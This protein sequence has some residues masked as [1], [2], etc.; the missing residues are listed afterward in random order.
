MISLSIGSEVRDQ[1]AEF[2]A[3][4]TPKILEQW[5]RMNAEQR[6]C[7]GAP[8]SHAVPMDSAAMSAILLLLA[9]PSFREDVTADA[10]LEPVLS[11][12]RAPG[13]QAC[14]FFRDTS[15]L[16]DAI[17]HVLDEYQGIESAERHHTRRTCLS[18]LRS[19]TKQV[20]CCTT[21]IYEHILKSG[22]RAF[23][24]LDEEGR[25]L[26][27]NERMRRLCGPLDSVGRLF[28]DLFEGDERRFVIDALN[29]TQCEQPA[30]RVLNISLGNR[31][32]IPVGVELGPIVIRGG[33]VGGFAC[34]VD[35]SI[36]KRAEKE[37]LRKS[38]IGIVKVTL[39]GVFTFCNTE[40]CRAFGVETLE[41]ASVVDFLDE[42]NLRIVMDQLEKRKEGMGDEYEI[43]LTRQTD[44]SRIP[45]RISSMPET[46]LKGNVVG[47]VA[48]VKDLTAEK[49]RKAIHEHMEGDME[50]LMILEAAID[51]IQRVMPF[52]R[53]YVA[54]YSSTMHH[55]RLLFARS[56]DQTP[57]R[58]FR[59][60]EMSEELI[61]WA[62]D[63]N[64][65]AIG[66]LRT[67]DNDPRWSL[68]KE[69]PEFRGLVDHGFTS[70]VKYPVVSEADA[71]VVTF[72]AKRGNAF[73]Q[74]HVELLRRLPLNMVVL[75]VLEQERKREAEFRRELIR[76][77]SQA[78][79]EISC[80]ARVLVDRL[81]E[82]YGWSNVAIFHVAEDL[83]KFQ[84]LHGRAGEKG[85][86][87]PSEYEQEIAKGVLGYVYRTRQPVNIPDIQADELF[88]DVYISHGGASNPMMSELC[89][90]IIT[91]ELFWILNVED[92]KKNAF[93]N[94]EMQ[95]LKALLS[96]I[97][98]F[99]D[100]AWLR[101]FLEKTLEATSDL[102]VVTDRRGLIKKVNPAG[103]ELLG[104]MGNEL[105]DKDFKERFKHLGFAESIEKADK[106]LSDLVILLRKDG[107]EVEVL[108]SSADLPH[109]VGG[110]VFIAKDRR[111]EKRAEE[112]EYLGQMFYEIAIQSKTP[113]S[114]VF[115]WLNDFKGELPGEVGQKTL[116]KTL[117]QLR[118]LELTFDRMALYDQA[119]SAVP[120][121]EMLL[122]IQ[123]VVRQ[124]HD[125]FPEAELK[126]IEIAMA[127][128]LPYLRG[129]LFQLTFCMETVLAHLLRFVPENEK[130]TLVISHD[131]HRILIEVKGFS[132]DPSIVGQKSGSLR[133]LVSRS[134]A[135]MALGESTIRS[136]ID[137]HRGSFEAHRIDAERVAF[138]IGLPIAAS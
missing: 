89:L 81:C 57:E 92:A 22:G 126:K 21:D 48:I 88:K 78:P 83:G 68:T 125:D 20:L 103:R 97:T 18:R 14:D 135:E 74:G 8:D 45:L 96:D 84:L 41:G 40:A 49:T 47:T 54:V 36:P 29:N 56:H 119:R 51:E 55:V 77:I 79:C 129:D 9:D 32:R 15:S 4:A 107:G 43:E 35:L 82:H 86:E 75:K 122:E 39:D 24:Q 109:P 5:T 123:E 101:F 31:E 60:W 72:I 100:L 42:V 34:L 90:P 67:F 7:E 80:L 134:R 98:V 16:M 138:R 110:K 37:I 104:Y 52:D 105:K 1:S 115:G 58:H 64:I 118:R 112:L 25:I 23:C 71:A 70:L 19:I 3:A 10:R 95:S 2:M 94:E 6:A 50:G 131:D 26:H 120:Y 65:C 93:A 17:E 132:P 87:F 12:L 69:A 124:V 127:E 13:Y 133:G 38:P 28:P 116:D 106:S 61:P 111:Y 53:C 30:M 85:F 130:I 91:N 102:V 108:M 137:N 121:T 44:G 73:D 11:M 59:W 113:L 33:K 66:D 136:F 128:G 46:D 99:L 117:R 76:E 114:L 63:M 62:R 27:V